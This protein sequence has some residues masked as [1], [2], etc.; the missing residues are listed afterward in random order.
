MD[1]QVRPMAAGDEDA[2]VVLSL[3][4]WAPV[5]A[6]LEQVLGSR[7]FRRLHPDWRVDQER[8]VR[9]TCGAADKRVWV[10]E[11]A[12]RAIGFVAVDLRPE[13]SEGEIWM[14]AVDP[15]SQRRG[16]G[17]GLTEYAVGQI[18]EAGMTLA[19]VE[20]GGDPGHAPARATYEQ[21]GF[22][23]LPIVRYFMTL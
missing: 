1:W 5:F 23:P 16:V 19:I 22:T 8:D 14:L 9:A 7:I 13:R 12:G 2:V 17:I 10:A 11:A 4:A 15:S 18:K 3:R 6:S 20:T 21:A